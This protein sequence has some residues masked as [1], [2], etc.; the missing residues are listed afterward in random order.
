MGA[1]IPEYFKDWTESEIA[2]A[3]HGEILDAMERDA[4]SLSGMSWRLIRC[5]NGERTFRS[6]ASSRLFT[7]PL[8]QKTG[9]I[10]ISVV[11]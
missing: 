11:V 1:G 4:E 10:I 5:D 9:S 6:K 7:G 3:G 8:A 2:H